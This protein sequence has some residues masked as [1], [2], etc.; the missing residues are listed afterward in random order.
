MAV[1]WQ[2]T[3]ADTMAFANLYLKVLPGFS[4]PT[5]WVYG[6][7][8]EAEEGEKRRNPKRN[9]I[10]IVTRSFGGSFGSFHHDGVITPHR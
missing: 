8:S 7:G 4:T 5:D 2:I 9:L 10:I 1:Y 3:A 6:G